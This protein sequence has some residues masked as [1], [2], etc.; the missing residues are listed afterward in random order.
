MCLVHTAQI[1]VR[2]RIIPQIFGYLEGTPRYYKIPCGTV[3]FEGI[4]QYL[5]STVWYLVKYLR[6]LSAVFC[7]T[8]N[9]QFISRMPVQCVPGISPFLWRP[10]DEAKGLYV[11]CHLD[12]GIFQHAGIIPKL[13]HKISEYSLF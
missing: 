5:E 12:F 8:K 6:V 7:Y 1:L 2:M 9:I 13:C 4:T 10:G 3:F 11:Y